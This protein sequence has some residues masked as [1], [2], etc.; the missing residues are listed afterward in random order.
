MPGPA[1]RQKFS[2]LR[3]WRFSFPPVHSF[4]LPLRDISCGLVAVKQKLFF[5][6]QEF[7]TLFYHVFL[8][9]QLSVLTFSALFPLHRIFALQV[10]LFGIFPYALVGGVYVFSRTMCRRF[11][12]YLF[13][14]VG[15]VQRRHDHLLPKFSSKAIRP[16]PILIF[17]SHKKYSDGAAIQVVSGI[18]FLIKALGSNCN[19]CEITQLRGPSYLIINRLDYRWYR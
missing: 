14:L 3:L 4:T 15:T 2:P 1:L 17:R 6:L 16:R 8:F 7:S 9:S 19:W 12:F 11:L 13:Q 10:L 5:S 18:F